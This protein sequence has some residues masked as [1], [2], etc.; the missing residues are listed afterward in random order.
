M[1]A[2]TFQCVIALVEKIMALIDCGD[3]RDRSGLV[4]E[5]F[6]GDMRWDAE[7]GHPGDTGAP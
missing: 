2:P 6:V 3:T 1:S 4:I 7:A 5:D